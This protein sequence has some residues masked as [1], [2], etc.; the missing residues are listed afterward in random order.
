MPS[1]AQATDIAKWTPTCVKRLKP[2]KGPVSL[3]QRPPKIR[4]SGERVIA[5][6]HLFLSL[7]LAGPVRS[8][9]WPSYLCLQSL[10]SSLPL[11]Q[12]TALRIGYT[13]SAT[14]AFIPVTICYYQRPCFL[15]AAPRDH[16][17][18]PATALLGCFLDMRP[19]EASL[20]SKWQQ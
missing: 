16:S 15:F 11:P 7:P 8:S 14:G 10:S 9:C 19:F 5:K 13:L 3:R 4:D 18:T 17:T 20:P 6:N 1:G 2:R 12:L